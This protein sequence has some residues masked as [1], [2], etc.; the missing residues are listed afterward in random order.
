MRELNTINDVLLT[1]RDFSLSDAAKLQTADGWQDVSSAQLFDYVARF[2]N[3]LRGWGVAKGERVAIV[4]ENRLEWAIADFACLALG[5]VDVPV[6]PTLT[7]EQSAFILQNSG[8]R[9]AVV[10]TRVQA[11]KLAAIAPQTSLEHVIVMDEINGDFSTESLWQLVNAQPAG[12]EREL[13]RSI[14]SV[15]P[16][17]LATIIYT[18]GTTGTPKGVMLTHGNVAA[19]MRQSVHC[20]EWTPGNR[21]ISFLPLSHITARHLDYALYRYGVTVAYCASFDQLPK[22]FQIIRPTIIVA[23]PRVYEKVRQEALRRVGGGLKRK[24]FD[25]ALAIGSRHADEVLRGEIP[26]TFDWKIADKIVLSKVRGAFGGAAQYFIS[27]GAP[28]G[29]DT[30]R[31][32]AAVGI[33]IYEGYGLTETSPV[34]ALNNQRDY[35]LGT[36]GVPLPNM[37]CRLAPDGELLV[38]GPAVF[39]GYWNMPQDTAAAFEADWFHTGDIAN[40]DAD[41]FLSIT[42]RKKDL[43]KTSGGKFIAPQPI[44]NK[45]KMDPLVAQAA[46]IG[47]ARKFFSVIIAPNF[48]MLEDWAKANDIPH[49]DRQELIAHPDV[50]TLYAA[51]VNKVNAE[52]AQFERLKRFILVPDEFS[53][54]SGELTPSLKLKRRVVVGKYTAQI[55]H[56]YS[57]A[58]DAGAIAHI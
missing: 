29:T 17:D 35:K 23:V 22:A 6:Y 12:L 33:R 28:L 46:V 32:Y 20:F 30:P 51:I 52:L 55:E 44:E 7:A 36:V 3:V 13:E 31:W 8:A 40:I 34:I 5:V 11:I 48:P 39:K 9:V 37:E 2:A 14:A 38:R 54:E 21:A 53:V 16:E 4:S 24:I 25:W 49:R 50:R 10:S 27:G 41:G 47:D 43:L 1:L 42:D 19:N 58:D 26:S 15:M 45:L 57:T 18:S 56:L